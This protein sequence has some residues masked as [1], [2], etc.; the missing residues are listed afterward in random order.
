MF[1]DCPLAYGVARVL[2]DDDGTPT[3]V[4]YIYANNALA[5][6]YHCPS[7]EIKGASLL[8]EHTDS[9]WKDRFARC[10][11]SGEAQEFET[12]TGP[13]T[14]YL[15]VCINQ[16]E[17]CL[18]GFYIQDVSDWV[19]QV[20][21]SLENA[22]AGLFFYDTN[23][24][25]MVL[26]ESTCERY[27]LESSYDSLEDFAK[28][29]FVE[30]R[31][32]EI[33][34][35]AEAFR[36]GHGSV[37]YEGLTNTGKWIRISLARS[38]RSG[39]LA[40]GFIEDI[41]KT[42]NLERS[43]ARRMDIIETLSRENFAL[44]LADLDKDT[45]TAYRL[46]ETT[47]HSASRCIA[48]AGSYD[49]ALTEYCRRYVHEGDQE[50]FLSKIVRPNV[51][52]ELSNHDGSFSFTYRRMKND[53]FEYLQMR[54]L[55]MGE[56]SNRAVVAIRNVNEETRETLRQKSL[57]QDALDMAEQAS[58]AKSEFLAN[59][60]HDFRT[61]MNAILGFANIALSH[62][63]DPERIRDC[64]KKITTSSNMPISLIND[65]LDVSRIESG[66][67][68]INE[69]PI[70]LRKTMLETL[71]I[72][73]VQADEKRI[74]FT[75]DDTG[76]THTNVMADPIRLNQVV[77]NLVG[78]SLKYTDEGGSILVRLREQ[79]S[80]PA[81]FGSFVLTVRDTGCGMNEDFLARMFD[82]FERDSNQ[83]K[84]HTE[85]TGLGLTITKN[86]V[87]MMGGTIK[88][89]SQIGV[90]SEF[91]VTLPLRLQENAPDQVD[92]ILT[93]TECNDYEFDADE[94]LRQNS[95][96]DPSTNLSHFRGK[97]ILVADDDELSRE[98]I[99][100]I[101]KEHGFIMDEAANGSEAVSKVETSSPFHYDAV[102]MDMQM[103][104]MGGL[105]A[106]KAIRS[107]VRDDAESVPI[108]AITGDA[109]DE[110]R[111]QALEAGMDRHI[112]KPV[113]IRQL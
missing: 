87:D 77:V 65:I 33:S 17:F 71:S 63:D 35:Q 64:L 95:S 76:V 80:A 18:C 109:Y 27:G 28:E 84:N 57:L 85:G 104:I 101:L 94:F 61:P 83:D 59:M 21:S 22:E 46:R 7:D 24:C 93:D 44:Y 14:G 39:T 56:N 105:E 11:C 9:E 68:T 69:E 110:N 90:G 108:I 51:L 92:E 102:L 53:G 113:D 99:V 8:T 72:F 79:S 12:I 96:Y 16:L 13:F 50:M 42:K 75:V 1:D 112:A 60:S 86:L 20:R 36:M 106:T 91:T 6:M 31:P 34:R 23:T 38:A 74:H 41:T 2:L 37:L 49:R 78:N 111:Q 58:S 55:S 26:S 54:V 45:I 10:G 3:D 107:M 81:G 47:P 67:L 4:I 32:D 19:S 97:R 52:D 88:V 29:N 43:G 48:D 103:P 66:K 30:N 100:E 62:I 73:Q 98:I 5:A 15:H 25:R 82:P 40:L 70:S 89:D